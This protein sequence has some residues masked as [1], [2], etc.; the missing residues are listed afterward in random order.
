MVKK[1]S[2][3]GKP[4]GLSNRVSQL[5]FKFEDREWDKSKIALLFIIW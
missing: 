2:Q 5:S 1:T 3:R 4:P